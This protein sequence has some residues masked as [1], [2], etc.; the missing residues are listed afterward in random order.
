MLTVR[1]NKSPLIVLVYEMFQSQHRQHFI[2]LAEI[3]RTVNESILHTKGQ[4]EFG[5]IDRSPLCTDS[6]F[7]PMVRRYYSETSH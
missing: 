2:T 6:H 4:K 5:H 1:L 3:T 7:L